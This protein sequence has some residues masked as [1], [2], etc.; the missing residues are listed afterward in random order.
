MAEPAVVL[1]RLGHRTG[2]DL[3]SGASAMVGRLVCQDLLTTAPVGNGPGADG[4]GI[5]WLTECGLLPRPHVAGLIAR[6]RDTGLAVLA[7]TTSPEVAA[8]LA[9]LVNVVVAHPMDDQELAGK[10]AEITAGASGL[11]A[12]R[13]REFLLAVRHPRRLVPRG[14]PVPPRIPRHPR[15]IGHA[16]PPRAWETA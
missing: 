1:F 3:A 10:L 5:V 14:R 4:G 15:Q 16:P 6:G 2:S 9:D 11:L 7:A 8:D 12:L 13:D